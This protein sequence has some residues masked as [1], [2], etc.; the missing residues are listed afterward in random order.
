MFHHRDFESMYDDMQGRVLALGG[1]TALGYN[2]A[3]AAHAI[4]Q[5]IGANE[6]FGM[7][8][9]VVEIQNQRGY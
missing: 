5:V 7:A 9:N 2:S 1:R 6:D 3:I 4:R 8:K